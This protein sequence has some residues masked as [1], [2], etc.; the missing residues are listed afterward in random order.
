MAIKI[1]DFKNLLETTNEADIDSLIKLYE[2]DERMGIKKIIEKYKNHLL[3]H[4]Q[5][6]I[7]T[8]AMKIF[9]YK[10]NEFDYIA[11]IDEVG[12]GPLAGP[13]VAC[14]VILDKDIE[15]LYLNDSKKLNEKKREELYDVIMDK[16]LAVGI[17]IVSPEIIDKIN[18]LQA[19]YEAMR[20]AIEKLK[21]Q[22]TILLND[23][24][25]IPGV[26]IKQ[27]AIV[28]GDEQSVSIAAAS[29]VAKVTR[30]RLMKQYHILFPE[31]NFT[32][33][34]GYGSKGHIEVL[35]TIG[36]SPIH[37]ESFIKNFI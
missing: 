36:P 10:Y 31:Y 12:R 21:I 32:S 35:K 5:E 7:R 23:A 27:V 9:E 26:K 19:T 34:K 16:A 30:D 11:G 29:I 22:P 13:V 4:Q 14:A 8:E 3:K 33:N 6:I 37:R 17:G 1:S 2:Q 25:H 24:V 18:I 20:I 15:I 28:K